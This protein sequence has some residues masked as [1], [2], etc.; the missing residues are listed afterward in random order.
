MVSIPTNYRQVYA[1][2]AEREKRIRKICPGITYNSGIYIFYRTGDNGIKH[3][4]CGQALKLCE[5]CASHLGEYDHIALSLKKRG[6]YSEDNPYG[7]KLSFK[8]CKKSELDQKEIETIKNLANDGFQMLNATS[9]GQGKGK[10]QLNEYKQPKTYRQGIQAGYIKAS[11]EISNLFE[12]Y[13]NYSTKDKVP[14]RY[15]LNALDKF[16]AFLDFHKQE[17]DKNE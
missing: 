5:R 2:K 4:Y 7:W 1:M 17:Q 13:L 8:E 15:Q 16:Q 14:N 10:Q 9:G 3:A 12:K 6:F 11:K